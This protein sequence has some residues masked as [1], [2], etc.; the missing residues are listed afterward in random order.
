[1]MCPV[2]GLGGADNRDLRFV[3]GMCPESQN[4]VITEYTLNHIRDPSMIKG[5]RVFWVREALG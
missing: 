4:P 5:H 2:A 3:G 1:M